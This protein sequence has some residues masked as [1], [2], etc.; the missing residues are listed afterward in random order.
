MAAVEGLSLNPAPDISW[1]GKYFT[2]T[3]YWMRVS[4][5]RAIP[6]R[7]TLYGTSSL[8]YQGILQLD[9][10]T[11][12]NDKGRHEVSHLVEAEKITSSFP[13]DTEFTLNSALVRV[14]KS[15]IL[16]GSEEGGYWM[17]PIRIEYRCTGG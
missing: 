16:S 2:P 11:R 13:Q 6:V 7:Q 15:Y 8:D 5:L 10:L 17:T 1:P 9:L 3:A 4:H 14:K 12:T